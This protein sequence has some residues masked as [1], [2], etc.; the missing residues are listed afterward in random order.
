MPCAKVLMFKNPESDLM[1]LDKRKLP[2]F[3]WI[4]AN[5]MTSMFFLCQPDQPEKTKQYLSIIS[6]KFIQQY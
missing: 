3:V 4:N 6:E 2:Y 5:G 1:N